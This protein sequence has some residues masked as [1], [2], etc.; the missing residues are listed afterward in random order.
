MSRRRLL[1][2]AP[3]AALAL[4][5]V[6]GPT[7]RIAIETHDRLDPSPERIEATIEMGSTAL[8]FLLTWTSHTR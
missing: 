5:M 8:S 1:L 2:I 7:G 6:A 4:M 3:I